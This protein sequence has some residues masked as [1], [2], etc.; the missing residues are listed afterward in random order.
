[1][2]KLLK[3]ISF[4]IFIFLLI[5]GVM[6][7]LNTDKKSIEDVTLSQLVTEINE[8]KVA[9][10]TVKGN[11]LEILLTENEKK[12][13]SRKEAESGLTETLKNY[14]VDETKLKNVAIEVKGESSASFW[15]GAILPILIP[16]ILII[17]FFWF[18]MRQA[19]RG[20]SQALSFGMSK[21]RMIDP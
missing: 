12:Q 9:Q 10:I 4:V 6:I 20:N 16:F 19:T 2:E 8:E 3:N 13:K 18:M 7:L 11:D 15:A 14:G 1:M 17:A 5:S 21:A